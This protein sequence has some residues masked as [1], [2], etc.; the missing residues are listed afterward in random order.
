MSKRRYPSVGT[1]IYCGNQKPPLSDEHVIPYGLDGDDVLPDASCKVC[2][3]ITSKVERHCLQKLFMPARFHLRQRSRRG[4]PNTLPVE[5]LV[6]GLKTSRELTLA[7]HPGY[8]WSWDLDPPYILDGL[9]PMELPR[10]GRIAMRALNGDANDRLNKL[11]DVTLPAGFDVTI[12][13]R[14]IAKIAHAHAVAMR[15]LDAFHPLAIE[16][17]LN[18]TPADIWYIVGGR[19]KPLPGDDF[20]RLEVEEREVI[21]SAFRRKKLLVVSVQL[22]AEFDMPA[23]AVVVG[24]L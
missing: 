16:A 3:G 9:E 11:G 4:L 2:A 10:G 12:F 23:H 17:I 18:D 14:M 21:T 13:A 20:H 8:L 15:G 1:C 19:S 7:E 22:F 24:E 5:A 6:N